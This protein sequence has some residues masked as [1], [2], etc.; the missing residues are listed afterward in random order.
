MA[1]A[2]SICHFF[3]VFNFR[4]VRLVLAVDFIAIHHM[5]HGKVVAAGASSLVTRVRLPSPIAHSFNPALVASVDIISDSV[6]IDVLLFHHGTAVCQ[7][8][9]FK[10][11]SVVF[12]TTAD[13]VLVHLPRIR[14][15]L[16]ATSSIR[17]LRSIA[18]HTLGKSWV[19]EQDLL[20]QVVD[21][22]LP[23]SELR[24]Q[25]I[26]LQLLELRL[27][28]QNLVLSLGLSELLLGL[29][30]SILRLLEIVSEHFQ[31]TVFIHGWQLLKASVR[32][33]DLINFLN[34]PLA[35]LLEHLDPLLI[36]LLELLE[37]VFHGNLGLTQLALQLVNDGL[38]L[39]QVLVQFIQLSVMLVD[40][41]LPCAF[42]VVYSILKLLLH[43]LRFVLLSLEVVL[44][45]FEF[46]V[47]L[48]G[49]LQSLALFGED[50]H[51]LLQLLERVVLLLDQDFD[52]LVQD[53][54]AL[55]QLNRN[56]SLFLVFQLFVLQLLCE[57]PYQ[58]LLLLLLLL[59][60]LNHFG[61]LVDALLVFQAF[62]EVRIIRGN[63]ASDL[64]GT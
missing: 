47:L 57:R 42:E 35:F 45:E 22:A 23:H 54:V 30:L 61:V 13:D 19:L 58:L 40:K 16:I 36:L 20:L 28:L 6:Q 56:L 48:D 33:M 51:Q 39:L 5:V 18:L 25:R 44:V 64:N 52:L 2:L 50:G 37:P 53:V 55:L 38:L 63:G 60:I 29:P 15:L 49:Q 46:L 27:V 11:I 41:A 9:G 34:V 21:I 32:V 8:V 12:I 3:C 1:S 7:I 43:L 62:A 4:I 17:L 10:L 24:G 31:T 14:L 26:E 59:Q